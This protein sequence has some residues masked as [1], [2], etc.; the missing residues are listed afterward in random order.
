MFEYLT[1]NPYNRLIYL[2]VKENPSND[3][4]DEIKYLFNKLNE[5][6][7]LLI[8][9]EHEVE[10]ICYTN[11]I[12]AGIKPYSLY[13]YKSHKN[14]S[15]RIKM[16][17][18]E[19]EKIAKSIIKDNNEIILLKNAGIAA[20]YSDDLGKCPMG[21]IDLLVKQ[22]DFINIHNNIIKSGFTL[23]FRNP[24][25]K[26]TT[27]YITETGNAEYYKDLN[28]GRMWLEMSI[29]SVSGRWIRPDQEPQNEILFKTS[30]KYKENM[31][32]LCPE[33]NLLQVCLHTAKHS[34]VRA[35][36]FRL[37]LD[38]ER[39][40]KG[41]N[42]DWNKF[43]GIVKEYNVKT[44]VY[45]SLIIP[46]ELFGTP[47]PLFVINTVRPNIIR[48]KYICSV[49]KRVNIMHPHKKKFNKIQ[50]ILFHIMLYESFQEI[51]KALFPS[52]NYVKEMYSIKTLTGLAKYY[53]RRIRDI[54]FRRSF[55]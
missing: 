41:S 55:I 53:I 50:F 14:T 2:C 24:N 54:I 8:A 12:K 21:D 27:K 40:V 39:I 7:F 31:K 11:I 34:F 4:L 18:N 32:I 33:Y 13:F 17:L 15:E 45:F 36:G 22:N 10:G 47:I 20:V 23:K 37:H 16:Y 30:I 25:E 49:L 51:F 26:A 46:L 35:P 38:V 42:I 6:Q 1:N 28:I 29:R 48:R 19:I 9:I 43:V 44:P 52:T 3:E 5:K